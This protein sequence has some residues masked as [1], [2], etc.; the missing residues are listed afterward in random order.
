MRIEDAALLFIY[1]ETPLHPGAGSG[2]GPIDNPV[3]REVTTGLPVIPASMVKGTLRAEF[4]SWV[5]NMPDGEEKTCR[6]REVCAV[7]G[8]SVTDSAS[9]TD[10]S[11]QVTYASAAAFTD[12]RLLA[13]PVRVPQGMFIWVTCP[14]ILERLRRDLAL[15]PDEI[16]P[17]IPGLPCLSAGCGAL[18]A[19]HLLDVEWENRQLALEDVLL[20]GVMEEDCHPD[21]H[22]GGSEGG[23]ERKALDRGVHPFR[24]SFLQF[25]SL[26]YPFGA[27]RE[28]LCLGSSGKGV[29]GKTWDY[30]PPSGG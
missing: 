2:I 15:I 8:P 27:G 20:E 28:R 3:Q 4:D 11:L 9:R 5:K 17:D 21:V 30:P 22:G 29:S 14:L 13:F 1:A 25:D 6:Q 10:R 16:R 24:D 7:F 12:A 23:E 19:D 18:V 26:H